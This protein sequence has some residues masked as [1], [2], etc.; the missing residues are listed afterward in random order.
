[1]TR[2]RVTCLFA[3]YD[4]AGL[5]R[6][7]VRHYLGEFAASGMTVHLALS[8][9]RD[10]SADIAR[11]CAERG[12]TP[13]LRPNR[14]MDFGAWQ[15]LLA[16]G[17]ARGAERIILANDSVFGP[18]R[19]LAPVLERMMARSADVWGLVESRF[20]VWHLQ[21][22]FLCFGADALAHPA[23]QR[24][25]ALP[26]A[27]MNKDEIILHGEMGLGTAIRAAGLR[28][29]SAWA[30]TA[31]GPRRLVPVNPMHIDWLSIARAPDTPFIKIELL[32]D[33][34]CGI[35]WTGAW[36]GL[37]AQ[38]DHFPA[39]W[40]DDMLRGRP[41]TACMAGWKS[42]LLFLLLS[43]DWPAILRAM[44]RRPP[45]AV[46]AMSPPAVAR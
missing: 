31:R 43:R 3:Q 46:P 34:P 26:F 6:P 14:G 21:S 42:R 40:I 35:G 7:H 44:T 22:W 25:L 9:A 12:I 11:F 19:P 28:A 16:A 41:D 18:L 32:R 30:D 17:C 45:A 36:R 8:G 24:V 33:N 23:I 37:L 27:E 5:L 38:R 4:P 10:L 1:M 39:A 15:D 29:A 13:H 2:P 20:P